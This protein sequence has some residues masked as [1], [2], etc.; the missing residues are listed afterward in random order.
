MK[1]KLLLEAVLDVI[2]VCFSVY[3]SSYGLIVPDY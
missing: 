1:I 3:I 2:L